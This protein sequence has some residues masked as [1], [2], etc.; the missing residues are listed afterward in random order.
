MH[1]Y[2]SASPIILKLINIVLYSSFV[3]SYCDVHLSFILDQWRI[4]D[5]SRG[6]ESP[7]SK[8]IDF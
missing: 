6:T 5:E 8:N 4:Y 3:K 1:F 2:I 7:E